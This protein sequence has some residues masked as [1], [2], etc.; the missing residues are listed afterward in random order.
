MRVQ[1]RRVPPRWKVAVAFVL[2]GLATIAV[3]LVNPVA[4]D[5]VAFLLGALGAWR[6]GLAV[7]RRS[8]MGRAR[9]GSGAETDARV[10]ERSSET[11]R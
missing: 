11:R 1:L 5:V 7:H 6:E 3:S 4:L 8:R 10:S 9:V 2:V